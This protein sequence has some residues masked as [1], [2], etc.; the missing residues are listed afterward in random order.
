MV[1]VLEEKGEMTSLH[2]RIA[3][4][5]LIM[6]DIAAVV[7]MAVTPGKV[8]SAWALLLLLLIPLRPLLYQLLHRVGDVSLR[9]GF[10]FR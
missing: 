3:I 10:G 7:F 6:Q 5:I 2:G 9:G 8:P 4:G 1:K